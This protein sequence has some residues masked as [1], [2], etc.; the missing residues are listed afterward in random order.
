M[1]TQR[2]IY[3]ACAFGRQLC[4]FVAISVKTGETSPYHSLLQRKKMEA[5]FTSLTIVSWAKMQL[6]IGK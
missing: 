5:D 1:E 3:L 2:D 4:A 6:N